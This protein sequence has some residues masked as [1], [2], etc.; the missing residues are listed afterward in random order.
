MDIQC[1]IILPT[2]TAHLA[3]LVGMYADVFETKDFQLPSDD[4]LQTLLK[5][6]KIIFMAAFANN[7]LAGGLTAYLLP[8]VY[9]ANYDV[10]LYDLAVKPLY[11]RNGIGR[12]LLEELK[13]YGK[14]RG[15]G[16]IFVQAETEDLHAIAFYRA[17]G[18]QTFN[19]VQ[20]AYSL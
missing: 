16:E 13:W 7:K 12:K 3:E 11:Q 18:G 4:W 15:Y 2:Q 19:A 10:Y 14:T 5:D 17:T 8:S 20:F 9:T 6:E 1:N